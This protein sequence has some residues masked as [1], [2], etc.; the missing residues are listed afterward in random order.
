MQPPIGEN[1]IQDSQQN[2]GGPSRRGPAPLCLDATPTLNC[3]NGSPHGFSRKVTVVA[4]C[5]CPEVRADR[6]V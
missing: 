5:H 3:G 4:G 2:S 6:R 1:A